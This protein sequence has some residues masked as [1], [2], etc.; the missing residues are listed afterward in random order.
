LNSQSSQPPSWWDYNHVPP[1]LA[2]TLLLYELPGLRCFAVTEENK[3]RHVWTRLLRHT[4]GYEDSCYGKY[5]VLSSKP[6][7]QKKNKNKWQGSDYLYHSVSNISFFKCICAISIK[8]TEVGDLAHAV[9]YLPSTCN[10]PQYQKKKTES[11]PT[12][13]PKKR[14]TKVV[15][16][17]KGLK[18]SSLQ[19]KVMRV[20][21]SL[22]AIQSYFVFHLKLKQKTVSLSFFQEAKT[23]PHWGTPGEIP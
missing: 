9:E 5:E 23:L 17:A 4:R 7:V 6:V 10:S 20:K 3:P 13:L 12:V 8:K 19:T 15:N 1:C 16:Q 18:S 2:S 22:N 11:N 14:K 21:G